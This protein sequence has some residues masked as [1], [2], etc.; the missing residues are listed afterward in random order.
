MFWLPLKR[1]CVV[2]VS[3]LSI[4]WL[5]NAVSVMLYAHFPISYAVISPDTQN[6]YC[7]GS[8]LVW[9][10]KFYTYTKYFDSTN[11]ML[12]SV[13]QSLPHILVL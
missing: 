12:Y 9:V 4:T 3:L 13:N 2:A 1:Y 7:K 10:L 11:T 6:A 5:F 8:D